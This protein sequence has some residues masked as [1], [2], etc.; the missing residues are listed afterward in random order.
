MSLN[1][2]DLL[3]MRHFGDDQQPSVQAPALQTEQPQSATAPSQELA[4]KKILGL[5][6]STGSSPT[7]TA[8]D[9]AGAKTSVISPVSLPAPIT[10][11][12]RNDEMEAKLKSILF[13]GSIAVAQAT[14]D[15]APPTVQ[16]AVKASKQKAKSESDPA[17]KHLSEVAEKPKKKSASGILQPPQAKVVVAPPPEKK[18]VKAKSSKVEKKI[19]APEFFASS[20]FL[21]SPDPTSVPLPDFDEKFFFDEEDTPVATTVAVAVAAP[22]PQLSEKASS[23]LSLL[24]AKK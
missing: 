5:K 14:Q 17:T 16:S 9:P 13:P 24:K 19:K 18:Q 23:L 6:I 21:S 8:S 15:T 22:Q 1:P 10:A 20:A 3:I 2:L 11:P 7:S 4:L 12:A